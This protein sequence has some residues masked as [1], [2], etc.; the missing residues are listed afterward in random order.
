[1]NIRR[2]LS[3]RLLYDYRTWIKL[4]GGLEA[5]N[6]LWPCIASAFVMMIACLIFYV[7]NQHNVRAEFLGVIDVIVL[8]VL[9]KVGVRRRQRCI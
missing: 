3:D 5:R 4:P 1:M 7:Q 6:L 9:G 2:R 8:I